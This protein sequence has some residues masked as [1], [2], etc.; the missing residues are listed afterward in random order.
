VAF[1]QQF[2]SG[3]HGVPQCPT[4]D[5]DPERRL[6]IAYFSPDL[7]SHPVSAFI[8]GVLASH[9]RARFEVWC[10]YLYPEEDAVSEK[11]QRLS[12]RWISCGRAPDDAV[13][14]QLRH[15]G[16]DLIVDLAG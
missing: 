16:I 6:R 2:G 12:D 5:P 14:E 8:G 13:V 7:R 15:D 4:P 1:D 11:L 10:Y 9:D 3:R